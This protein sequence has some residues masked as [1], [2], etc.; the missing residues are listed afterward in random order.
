MRAAEDRKA[1]RNATICIGPL[2]STLLKALID[3]LQPETQRPAMSRSRVSITAERRSLTLLIEAKDTSALRATLNSYL[4]WVAL[5]R[6]TYLA[7][8]SFEKKRL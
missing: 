1:K 6:D 5:V 3:A 8:T 2:S 7:T 4:R